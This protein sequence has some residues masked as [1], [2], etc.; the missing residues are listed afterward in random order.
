ML[1]V[2]V[3]LQVHKEHNLGEEEGAN[4]HLD[5]E[6]HDY[7][8]GGHSNYERWAWMQNEIERISTEQQ[9][10]GVEITGL[11]N[12][13]LRGNRMNE[14]NNLEHD[15]TPPPSR[16]SLWTSIKIVS[17]LLPLSLLSS[18]FFLFFFLLFFSLFFYFNFLILNH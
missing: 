18:S 4:L 13:V 8:A 5:E 10:Q 3:D 16:S 12:D 9:R 2:G 1:Y 17:F 7:E 11:Q 15:A 14:E 6:H